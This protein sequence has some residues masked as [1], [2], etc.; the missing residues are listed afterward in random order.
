MTRHDMAM[1]TSIPVSGR[2]GLAGRPRPMH[3]P[4]KVPGRVNIARE[5]EV[6]LVRQAPVYG[7]SR[8]K[9]CSIQQATRQSGCIRC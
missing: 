6:P 9:G 2:G 1:A 4:D 8:I 3:R 7:R 5:V